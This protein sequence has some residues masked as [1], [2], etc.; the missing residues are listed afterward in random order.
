MRRRFEWYSGITVAVAVAIM[1]FAIGQ[2]IVEH[3][4]DPV[5]TA[6]VIP[7]ALVASLR[8]R[9]TGHCWPRSRQRSD[10]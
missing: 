5:W 1:G 9:R 2:A 10:S 3:R 8:R 6:A 7:A 4:W